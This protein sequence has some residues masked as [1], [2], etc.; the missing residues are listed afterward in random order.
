MSDDKMSNELTSSSVHSHQSNP[1]EINPNQS[2]YGG[3]AL[4][5]GK[6][7]AEEEKYAG[8]IIYMFNKGILSIPLGTTLRGYLSE[9]LHW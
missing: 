1:E 9:K 8:K 5:R 3:V 4:R 7:T 6:W 2:N